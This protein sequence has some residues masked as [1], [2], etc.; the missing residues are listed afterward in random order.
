MQLQVQHYHNPVIVMNVDR[1]YDE[2]VVQDTVT[3]TAGAVKVCGQSPSAHICILVAAL[4]ALRLAQHQWMM[5]TML[6][7]CMQL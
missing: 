5:A 2:A 6:G 1:T 4:P 7:C 3:F